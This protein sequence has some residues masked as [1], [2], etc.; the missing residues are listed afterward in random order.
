M[1]FLPAA[2]AWWMVYICIKVCSTP[3]LSTKNLVAFSVMEWKMTRLSASV[4]E[5]KLSSFFSFLSYKHVWW[6][7]SMHCKS[8]SRL[9][10]CSSC[11]LPV[12]SYDLF[13][14]WFIF[15]LNLKFCRN[16]FGWC[17]CWCIYMVFAVANYGLLFL[18]LYII[19]FWIDCL[20]GW[21]NFW[22]KIEVKIGVHR[23]SFLRPACLHNHC[24]LQRFVF[25][26]NGLGPQ[27]SR[28]YL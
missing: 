17:C 5:W 25:P 14:T 26:R 3:A 7:V 15:T 21:N 12:Y 22:H 8:G 13:C 24:N 10:A 23:A 6:I 18:P 27:W 28:L 4:G 19:C 9:F 16:Y 2:A 1:S 11:A 20:V